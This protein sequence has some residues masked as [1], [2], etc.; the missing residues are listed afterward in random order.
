MLHMV[1]QFEKFPINCLRPIARYFITSQIYAI[2]SLKNNK[3]NTLKK[4]LL[5]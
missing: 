3:E 5:F 1:R 2:K 4:L